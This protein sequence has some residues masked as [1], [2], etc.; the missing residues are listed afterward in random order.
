ML[1]Y[2]LHRTTRLKKSFIVSLVLCLCSGVSQLHAKEIVRLSEPTSSDAKSE[3]FG[4]K[5]DTSLPKTTLM[6][7]MKNARTNLDKPLLIETKVSKVCQKKGCFFIAQQDDVFVR[8]S[9]KDYDFFIPTDSTNKT[10]L[11]N[12]TLISKNRTDE[13]AA[14]F[15]SDLKT[16]NVLESGTVYEIVASSIRVPRA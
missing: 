16:D 11:L 10:V 3:T 2:V 8:V 5:L 7:L 1:T 4:A 13:Q 15:N 12:G 14:H 6:K 9:F